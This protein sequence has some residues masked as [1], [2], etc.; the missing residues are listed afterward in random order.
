MKVTVDVLIRAPIHFH[1][2]DRQMLFGIISVD[3]QAHQEPAITI[4]SDL[5]LAFF[6]MA[7]MAAH[8]GALADAAIAAEQKKPVLFGPDG[9]PTNGSN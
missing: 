9:F 4:A 2:Y 7:E 3:G 5:R 6:S 8:C 1:G